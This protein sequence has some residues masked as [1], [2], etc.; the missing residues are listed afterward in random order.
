VERAAVIGMGGPLLVDEEGLADVGERD[1][2]AVAEGLDGRVLAG[3]ASRP[4][5]EQEGEGGDLRVKRR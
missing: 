1:R 5:A 3:A 2:L 4:G